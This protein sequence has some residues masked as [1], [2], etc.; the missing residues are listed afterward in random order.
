MDKNNRFSRRTFLAILGTSAATLAVSSTGLG[1]LSKEA[2]AT[3]SNQVFFKGKTGRISMKFKPIQAMKSDELILPSGIQSKVVVAYGDQINQA[4]DTFGFNNGFLSYFPLN[5]SNVHG[6][7]WVSHA[8]IQPF[9]GTGEPLNKQYTKEQ[10]NRALYD[11]GGSIIEV[12]RDTTGAWGIEKESVYSRRITG[13]SSFQLT[14][15]VQGSTKNIPGT[16]NIQGLIGANAGTNT[17]WGTVLAC[18]SLYDPVWHVLGAPATHYG[19]IAEIDPLDLNE[20]PKKHSALGRF[21]HGSAVMSLSNDNKIVVHMSDYSSNGCLYKYISHE[22]FDPT[23]GKANSKL[24]TEGKLYAANMSE[25]KW[26]PLSLEAVLN[27]LKDYKSAIPKLLQLTREDLLA[28][29][30]EEADL[31]VHTHEAAILLGA[32]PLGRVMDMKINPLDHSIYLA[33]PYNYESG[34]LHG[35]IYKLAESKGNFGA[36]SFEF[37]LVF[38]GGRQSGYS[39]PKQLSFNRNGELWISTGIPSDKLNTGSWEVFKNNSLFVVPTLDQ[40]NS[41]EQF[42]AAPMEAEFAG[43]WFTPDEQ[44]LFLS[45][46]HPGERTLDSHQPTSHWPHRVGDQLPRSAVVAITGF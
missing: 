32:T 33:Q 40:N 16:D 25:G 41:A 4:G 36:N 23:L 13:T 30:T 31:L 2:L 7:L 38:S 12:Y 24:L 10:L 27:R 39:S 29:F 44:T 42:A 37:D 45:V 6:L 20:K 22:A 17:L 15:V 21:N 35:Q 3:G 14:G 18:E 28:M 26:I 46:Q 1:S 8:S 11:H 43:S 19:W 9:W 5:H 34:N